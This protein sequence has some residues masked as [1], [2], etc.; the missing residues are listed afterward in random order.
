[1]NL[2]EKAEKEPQTHWKRGN[3]PAQNTNGLCPKIK[4]LQMGP[5]KIE[6]LL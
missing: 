5:H 1:M 6:K 3:F 4:N 2:I